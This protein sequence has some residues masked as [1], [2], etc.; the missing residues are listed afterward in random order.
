VRSLAYDQPGRLEILCEGAQG[1]HGSSSQR[2][3]VFY[4]LRDV[5]QRVDEGRTPA[6]DVCLVQQ[7]GHSATQLLRRPGIGDDVDR[8]GEGD[9]GLFRGL[10]DA[11]GCKAEHSSQSV[12]AI[13]HAVQGD[14]F[15]EGGAQHISADLH[16]IRAHECLRTFQC[17]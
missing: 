9:L 11:T 10:D 7:H 15:L 16:T 5:G 14:A 6:D 1:R 4:S 3:K 17:V 2:L 8:G 12:V 13:D